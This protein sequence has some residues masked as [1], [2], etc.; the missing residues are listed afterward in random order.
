MT[1]A[2]DLDPGV[3]AVDSDAD[4]EQQTEAVV[5][6]TPPVLADEWDIGGCS[7]AE[8]PGNEPYDDGAPVVLV[9]YRDE[10]EEWR[11]YRGAE[12]IPARVLAAAPCRYYAFPRPRLEVV[13]HLDDEEADEADEGDTD[14]SPDTDDNPDPALAAIADALQDRRVSDVRVADG[15]G[16]VECEKLGV[17]YHVADDG[18]VRESDRVVEKLETIAGDVL[19]DL[20]VPA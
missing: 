9:A 8:Y 15:A 1:D 4:P 19:A 12:P 16:V 2:A 18:S 20:E 7:V 5:V 6:N 10:L 11:S 3:L 17:T 14:D 13:G